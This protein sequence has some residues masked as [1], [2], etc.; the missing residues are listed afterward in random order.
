VNI[1]GIWEQGKF[2]NAQ[3]Q[4]VVTSKMVLV[5]S[6]TKSQ[7]DNFEQLCHI[8]EFPDAPVVI[9]GAGRVGRAVANTLHER[10]IDYRIIDKDPERMPNSNK[11]VIGNAANPETLKKAGIEKSPAVIITTQDDDTNIYLTIYCRKRYPDI[12]IISRTSLKRNISTLRRAG[13]DFVISYASMGAEKIFNSLK[14]SDI[15]MVAEGLDVFRIKTPPPL[16]G[17]LIRDTSIRRDTG[18]NIIAVHSD[19]QSHIN[20]ES[21]VVLKP[22]SELVLIGTDE[23]ENCFLKLYSE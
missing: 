6:G 4:T 10:G 3:A 14:R 19:G 15:L 17:K 2:E 18:C 1:V 9:I 23:A 8:H 20:P 21:H 7:I 22:N 16:V 5:M 13:V 12:Q 11:L